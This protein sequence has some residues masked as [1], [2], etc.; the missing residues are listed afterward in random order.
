MT[1]QVNGMNIKCYDNGGT[2]QDRYTVCFVD[3]AWNTYP[4]MDEPWGMVLALA[5]DENPSAPWGF[6]QHTGA[7][8]GRHLGR[9]IRFAA[10]PNA[11]QVMVVN[12]IAYS[13]ES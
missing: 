1:E 6:G 5:M 7:V 12:E 13:Q 9:R 8:A 3:V 11:C 2:S 10:L 4:V